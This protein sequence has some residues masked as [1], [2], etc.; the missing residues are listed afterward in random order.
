M[1]CVTPWAGYLWETPRP[2]ELLQSVL[3]DRA[4][5]SHGRNMWWQK[6]SVGAEMRPVRGLSFLG[7]AN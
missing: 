7:K 2:T 5:K 3:G 6:N 1:N 4:E